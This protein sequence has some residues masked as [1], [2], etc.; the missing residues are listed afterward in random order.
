MHILILKIY[1]NN[2][3]TIDKNKN[4]KYNTNKNKNKTKNN[5]MLS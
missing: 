2:D 5:E 4:K 1:K 3:K